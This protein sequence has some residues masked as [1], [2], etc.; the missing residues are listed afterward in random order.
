ML[1]RFTVLTAIAVLAAAGVLA[2]VLA[3]RGGDA[4]LVSGSALAEAAS[5]TSQVPGATISMHISMKIDGLDQ[6]I[7]AQLDGVTSRRS[8]S[9][10]MAGAYTHFP[11]KIPGQRADGSVPIESI[12]IMPRIYMKSPIFASQLPDGKDWLSYDVAKASQQLGIGDPTQFNQGDPMHSLDN[13]RA[14]S[15]RVEQV[16]SEDV[17]H[18]PTTH[19]KATVELRKLPEVVPAAQRAAARKAAERL[20]ALTG[21]DSYPIEVWIDRRHM[22]RRM[23]FTIDMKFAQTDRRMKMDMTIEMFDFGPKPKPN[24]P[25]ADSVYDVT[26]LAGRTP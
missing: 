16:G 17:R 11:K 1:R 26:K 10:R 25:P 22:V 3:G 2:L 9:A 7:E 6:P 12:A 19:Y 15:D 18:V 13:L 20:I 8:R 24:A 4:N 5:A 14:T 23:R 21:T